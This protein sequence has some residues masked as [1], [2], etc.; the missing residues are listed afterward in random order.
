MYQSLV[1]V[2]LKTSVVQTWVA[3]CFLILWSQIVQLHIMAVVM[4]MLVRVHP[5]LDFWVDVCVSLALSDTLRVVSWALVQ[6]YE[7]VFHKLLQPLFNV[8]S[9]KKRLLKTV[10]FGTLTG[11]VCIAAKIAHIDENDICIAALQVFAS[12]LVRTFVISKTARAYLTRR[13]EFVC[14]RFCPNTTVRE[15]IQPQDTIYFQKP[16]R[17]TTIKVAVQPVPN[18]RA[19]FKRKTILQIKGAGKRFRSLMSR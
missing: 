9:R 13:V 12:H 14:F 18:L 17:Q 16:A 4:M 6:K 11:Y 1:E 10:V 3:Y 5:L 19:R 15:P 8:P 2:L 7:H